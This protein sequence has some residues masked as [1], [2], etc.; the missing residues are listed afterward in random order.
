M[1]SATV[2][3]RCVSAARAQVEYVPTSRSKQSRPPA[4]EAS[5]QTVRSLRRAKTTVASIVIGNR[6]PRWLKGKF[7]RELQRPG[8][9]FLKNRIESSQ[10]VV[11][12]LYG[13]K[14]GGSKTNVA[15][16]IRK[17]GMVQKIECVRAKLQ[18]KP[19]RQGKLPSDRHVHFCQ[20][21]PANVISSF[22]SLLAS[23]RDGECL[24]IKA[25]APACRRIRN[26]NSLPRNQIRAR[27]GAGDP[28]SQDDCIKRESAP[29]YDQTIK[30]PVSGQSRQQSFLRSGWNRIAQRPGKA[31]THIE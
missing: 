12:H 9:A 13:L 5:R 21:Q 4:R 30:R 20:P 17:I 7:E 14:V 23:R 15:R 31:L 25:L 3:R 29:R 24:R 6:K 1:S 10:A 27:I 22:G 2:K 28:R 18:A 26:P 16:W 19:L 8:T 11:E